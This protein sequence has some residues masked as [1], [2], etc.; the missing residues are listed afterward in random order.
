MKGLYLIWSLIIIFAMAPLQA[1]DN[2]ATHSDPVVN[3]I[4]QS[5]TDDLDGMLKSRV[6]RV[7]V[8]PSEIMFHVDK[9]KKQGLNYELMMLFQKQINADFPQETKH[10]KTRI[11]FIPVAKD[12]LI[13]GL[14]KGMGDIAVGDISITPKRK[15]LVD[16][17]DPYVE[18]I[19]AIVVT[20]SSS[21][22]I[23][24]LADLSEKEV[25]VHPSSSYHEYLQKTNFY[26]SEMGLH[27]IKIK[28]V[29]EALD[30]KDIL[31]ILNTGLVNITVMDEYLAKLWATV[32]TNIEVH[33]DIIVKKDDAFAWMI[34]KNSPKLMQEINKFIKANK[35]GSLIGNTL[36]KRYVK[37]F[38]YEEPAISKMKLNTFDEDITLFKKY[39]EQYH[40][41]YLLLIAQAYQESKLN[42]KARSKAGAIGIMQLMPKTG[43]SMKVGDITKLE[44]N[45]HAGIKY[46]RW[47]IDN[48]FNDG[49]LDTLNQTLFAFASYN[50]GPSR[51]HGLRKLAKERGYDP[52]V[53]FDN[54]EMIAAEKIGAETVDYVS[55]IYEYYVAYYLYEEKK[56]AKQEAINKSISEGKL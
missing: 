42:Q 45:I 19:N 50:A 14:L 30:D 18:H 26:L 36:I 2:N 10:L 43:K 44:P 27:P 52:N 3:D 6:I 31:E 51:I 55:N 11:V 38:K 22:S 32:F 48:Y 56:Q 9:G 29:P 40:L 24:T 16:F 49:E 4:I 15:R 37:N 28:D 39:A 54:V 34:R 13:P 53:W 17:S 33:S 1:T 41:N 23:N 47:I 12:K 46:H 25:Y 8:I 5:R 7:L 20:G 21:P 35:K